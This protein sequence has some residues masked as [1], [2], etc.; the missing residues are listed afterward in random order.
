MEDNK[1]RL[2]KY[3]AS[4]GIA[5]R[6][7]CEELITKG[8]VKV[9]GKVVT[10]LGT[11]VDPKDEVMVN[12]KLISAEVK[13]YYIIN[14]PAGYLTT[15]SDKEGR[16]VVTDLI[17]K[18]LIK[19]RLFSIGRLDYN[20]A[21][22]LIL[23]NDGELTNRLIKSHKEISKTYQLRLD[24]ILSQNNIDNLI[25]GVINSKRINKADVE[26]MSFDRENNS[27]LLKISFTADKTYNLYDIFESLGY[28]IKKMKRYE[29]AGITIEGL[30]S[31]DYRPLKPHE[32]KKLYSL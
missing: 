18:K 29:F 30:T 26:I 32:I 8:V 23:T 9:N 10:E 5:S 4:C 12:D 1:I 2:Q 19:T 20:V 16:K 13:E 24:G 27:T 7:K 31:G 25:R 6:R 21:G 14:K 22:A 11:K 3:M 28:K 17:D 15:S